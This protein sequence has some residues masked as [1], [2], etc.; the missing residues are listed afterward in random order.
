MQK[1][2]TL[3]ELMVVVMIVGLL[4]TF[5]IPAYQ[6]YTVRARVAEG[7]ALAVAAK[8][9]VSD[10]LTS[11]NAAADPIGYAR[12][13]AAPAATNN[14]AAVSIAPATG[15]VTVLTSPSAGNGSLLLYPSVAAAALPNGTTSFLPPEGA[16]AWRCAA[17]GVVLTAVVTAAGTLP[18][19]YAP[20]ECR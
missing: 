9:N 12:G 18:A 3:L 11:G 15:V 1:G 17:A 14:I 19:T 2:F 6:S 7:L 20:S 4:A 10:V 16:L 5:A 13:Y 8:V